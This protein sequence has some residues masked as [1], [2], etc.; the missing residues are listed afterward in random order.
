MKRVSSLCFAL[1]SA[2]LITPLLWGQS[3]TNYTFSNSTA[4][5]SQIYGQS[6]TTTTTLSG[7]DAVTGMIPI[8]F[9]FV[10]MGQFYS[11]V[12]AST[13]G[14]LCLGSTAPTAYTN[15]LTSQTPRPIITAF[16]DD[17]IMNS[18]VG[19]FSYRTDGT[20]PNRVFTAE[21]YNVEFLSGNG[22]LFSF[23]IKLY[24]SSGII[25]FR[26]RYEDNSNGDAGSAS[27]GITAVGTGSGNFLSVNSSY[28]AV[29]S[30]TE[31]TSITTIP[32]TNTVLTFTPPQ[33][34]L[35]APTNLTFTNVLPGQMTL[36]WQDNTSNE[37][38]YL[39]QRSTDGTNYTNVVLTS[40]NATSYTAT[41]LTP[42]TTY[43]WRIYAMSEGKASAALSGTQATTGPL[44]CG[45]RQIPSTNYPNIKAA[46]DSI[47]TLGLACSVVFELLS[48]Y[49]SSNE[50]AFPL[51]FNGPIPGAS[52]SN[53]VTFRPASGVSSVVIGASNSTTILDLN[54][55]SWVRFDGRPGGT[56][57]TRALT[58]A[59]VNTAASAG[60]IRLYNGATNNTFQYCRIL[61]ATTGTST[62]TIYFGSPGTSI[63]NRKNTFDNCNIG[64]TLSTTQ[65]AIA[66]YA[67]GTTTILSD[68]NTISNCNIYNYFAN[69]T[70]YG[71][72]G[73]TGYTRWIITGNSFYQTTARTF[74]SSVTFYHIYLV[75]STYSG[76]HTI[77]GQLHRRHS[78][79]R[80]WFAVAVQYQ[81]DDAYTNHVRYL[82]LS[83]HEYVR[84]NT[85]YWKCHHQSLLPHSEYLNGCL[86][87]HLCL[88]REFDHPKQRGRQRICNERHHTPEHN[89]E[90]ATDVQR[91]LWVPLLDARIRGDHQREHCRWNHDE[92]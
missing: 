81:H 82:L 32:P 71:I 26:Y 27:I 18:G 79:E 66:V 23:Q 53:T 3:I 1:F 87:W 9:D 2:A 62:G 30:T 8:G 36:N 85:D 77:S 43:Y 12:S 65:P 13:N 21:W 54:G 31:T 90:H 20:S 17:L 68:S 34:T 86:Q 89:D 47:Y 76:G 67:V 57:T 35:D 19:Y 63:G 59:N 78:A 40:P 88:R 42:S 33:V 4:T 14:V 41:G 38:G 22:D 70:H 91:D 51:V 61:G 37:I 75:G 52:S 72:F 5:F 6:G 58:I 74:T 84:Y 49:S 11:Q 44:L 39:I 64:D 83:R 45:T 29:S 48:S 56:G 80:R 7:D 69:T 46:I 60:T 73:S 24:E 15:N 55:A 50:P 16:W 92:C 28:N 25:E 10:F